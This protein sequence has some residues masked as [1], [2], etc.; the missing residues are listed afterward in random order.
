MQH[1]SCHFVNV[2]KDQIL[3]R[4]GSGLPKVYY[5]LRRLCFLQIT[6]RSVVTNY[7]KLRESS[8]KL[9]Q[10]QLYYSRQQH[11]IKLRQLLQI[12]SEQKCYIFSIIFWKPDISFDLHS[13]SILIRNISKFHGDKEGH[14]YWMFTLYFNS[15]P[16]NFLTLSCVWLS[17]LLSYFWALIYLRTGCKTGE[18]IWLVIFSFYTCE[19]PLSSPLQ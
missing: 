19:D 18:K 10:V 4:P 7:Y 15:I 14:C 11:Y 12:M 3:S 9:W 1:W 13:L 5:K 16:I 17:A 2:T 8:Y 6:R